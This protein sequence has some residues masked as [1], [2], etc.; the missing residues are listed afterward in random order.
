MKIGLF[1]NYSGF[2]VIFSSALSKNKVDTVVHIIA[3]ALLGGCI[4]PD[5]ACL[6]G[7][8]TDPSHTG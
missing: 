8:C 2:F 7:G 5:T 6:L 3:A 4:L 1:S